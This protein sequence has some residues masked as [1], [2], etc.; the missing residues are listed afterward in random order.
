MRPLKLTAS[1][2]AGV[3]TIE[4][5]VQKKDKKVAGVL[6]ALVP[7]DPVAHI[8]LFRRDQSDFDGTFVLR[9][10]DSRLLH[11]RRRR[12]CL[13]PRV[14]SAS[15]LARYVQH[16]QNLTIGELMRGTVYLARS[17]RSATSLS[18]TRY[19]SPRGGR[20]STLPWP[21]PLCRIC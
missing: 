19:V 9:G 1:L 8:D 3:V 13:G 4:G 2:A 5:V 21:I 6:V 10:R 11:H 7:N 17:N 14:A 20:A 12:G 16:G 15:V 18:R